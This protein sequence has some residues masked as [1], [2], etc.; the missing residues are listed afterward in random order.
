MKV[1]EQLLQ[2]LPHLGIGGP[3]CEGALPHHSAVTVGHFAITVGVTLLESSLKPAV[4]LN[5]PLPAA[6]DCSTTD[7]HTMMHPHKKH[8]TTYVTCKTSHCNL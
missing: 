3:I 5:W 1:G 8:F 2:L 7:S 6:H 4:D